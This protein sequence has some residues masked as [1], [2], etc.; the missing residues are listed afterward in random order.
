MSKTKSNVRKNSWQPKILVIKRSKQDCCLMNSVVDINICNNLGLII[1]FI[2]KLT[3][4]GGS[5]VDRV[6]LSCG[7]IWIR[8]VLENR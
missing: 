5:T 4:V 8:L 6:S 1:D 2:G 3:K 7:I